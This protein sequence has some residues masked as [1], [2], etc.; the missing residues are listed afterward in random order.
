VA[1]T[2][3]Q[4]MTSSAVSM[5]SA[6]T[7]STEQQKLPL[8]SLTATVIG[9][10]LGAGI[11]NLTSRFAMATGPFGALIAGAIAGTGMYTL[12]RIYQ[13]LV[14][15]RP[16]IDSGVF[17]YATAGFGDYVGSLSASGYWFGSVLGNVFCWVLIGSTLGRFF[18]GIFE[19]STSVIASVVSLIGVCASHFIIRGG[20]QGVALINKVVSHS[21]V[22]PLILQSSSSSSSL[23]V[24]SS[25]R[26]SL[27]A[28][29]CRKKAS[30]CRCAT[31]C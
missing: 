7:S 10:M 8:P 22:V 25:A 27:M 9:S 24:R 14:E 16:V 18:P 6:V 17:A 19:D 13:F 11:F 31:R 21:D 28:S 4:R 23:G 2:V 3:G 1:N 5:A 29:A 15:K 30:S 12:A 26:I 20:V